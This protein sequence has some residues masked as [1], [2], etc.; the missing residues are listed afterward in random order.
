MRHRDLDFNL[1]G[2][3][4]ARQ[5]A[6]LS[7]QA[8]GERVKKGPNTYTAETVAGIKSGLMGHGVKRMTAAM[9]AHVGSQLN[10]I[11]AGQGL[12]VPSLWVWMRDMMT[13]ATVE[14]FYG[15][16]NPFRADPAGLDALWDLDEALD[17]MLFLPPAMARAGARHR[18]R[19]VSTLRPYFD[20][21]MDLNEDVSEF[22]A[23]RTAAP[24][25]RNVLGDDL[26]KGEVINI[27]VSTANSIPALSWTLINILS[28]PDLAGKICNE[29]LPLVTYSIKDGLRKATLNLRLVE[30]QCP[31]L[32]SCQRET[33]RAIN[34]AVARRAVTKDT[35]LTDEDGTTYVLKKG[36]DVMWSS[37]VAHEMTEVWGPDA[38][39]IDPER[40]VGSAGSY[41]SYADKDLERKRRAASHLSHLCSF[42]LFLCSVWPSSCKK[43]FSPLS[44]LPRPY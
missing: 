11:D 33:M 4:F 26:C 31:L 21:R 35:Q 30:K 40:F 16:A 19:I 44:M 34:H 18:D 3:A 15:H 23:L 13:M 8:L 2:L 12:H 22:V 24:V 41:G 17:S 6:D 20:E 37:K 1:V 36:N 7:H 43:E 27:W 25:K 5:V 38:L 28:R 32:L 39:K 9:L 14:V 10:P 29:V 42:F